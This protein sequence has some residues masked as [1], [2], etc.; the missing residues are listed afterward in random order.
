MYLVINLTVADM[1]VG[2]F[3]KLYLFRYRLLHCDITKRNFITL[4]LANKSSL[5][6]FRFPL[7]PLRQTLQSF[8]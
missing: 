2:G 4:E 6:Y 7:R 8:H 5:V 3:S 1:F